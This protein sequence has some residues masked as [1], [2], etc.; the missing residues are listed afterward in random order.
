MSNT[1]IDVEYIGPNTLRFVE[2]C[3]GCGCHHEHTFDGTGSTKTRRSH[4]PPAPNP[5]SG[6]SLTEYTLRL[7]IDGI[8]FICAYCHSPASTNDS[9]RAVNSVTCATCGIDGPGAHV[10]YETLLHQL[11]HNHMLRLRSNPNI[12]PLGQQGSG[13]RVGMA[14]DFARWP[15]VMVGMMMDNRPF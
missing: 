12:G 2:P 6:P 13:R 5:G 15:F 8:E 3:P 9:H 4:C 10:M 14:G 1:T 7:M 11:E